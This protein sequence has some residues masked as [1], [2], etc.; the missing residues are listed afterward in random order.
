MASSDNIIRSDALPASS[1]TASLEKMVMNTTGLSII[2]KLDE[3]DDDYRVGTPCSIATTKSFHTAMEPDTEDEEERNK[4]VREGKELHLD[5]SKSKD[6]VE[7]EEKTPTAE[8]EMKLEKH[9]RPRR[10]HHEGST[11]SAGS[12]RSSGS[13][14]KSRTSGRHSSRTKPRKSTETSPTSVPPHRSQP[15]S[16]RPSTR[17]TTTATSLKTA[18]SATSPRASESNIRP[19]YIPSNARREQSGSSFLMKNRGH[20]YQSPQISPTRTNTAT[21]SLKSPL[22][23]SRRPSIGSNGSSGLHQLNLLQA[24]P[25]LNQSR[26][27]NSL[28]RSSQE[29]KDRTRRSVDTASLHEEPK[30]RREQSWEM[31]PVLAPV[32]ICWNSNRKAN[33]VPTTS[34]SKS[35]RPFGLSSKGKASSAKEGFWDAVR[36]KLLCFS[37]HGQMNSSGDSTIKRSFIKRG[38]VRE[39]ATSPIESAPAFDPTAGHRVGKVEKMKCWDAGS[40]VRFQVEVQNGENDTETEDDSDNEEEAERSGARDFPQM[41]SSIITIKPAPIGRR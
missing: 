16:R 27:M 5:L 2:T 37:H 32:E 10:E 1:S 15:P 6:A 39:Y 11:T 25:S 17:R 41:D 22:A 38:T 31:H 30:A 19:L 7:E 3:Y 33:S 13:G 8:K 23:T 18:S 21:G 20:A 24:A 9:H 36:R 14:S 35:K 26:S 29:K 4:V 12:S 40:V 34:H 28:P